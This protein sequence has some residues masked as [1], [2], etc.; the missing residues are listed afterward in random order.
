MDLGR[1]MR[2]FPSGPAN[3][4]RNDAAASVALIVAWWLDDEETFRAVRVGEMRGTETLEAYVRER[5]TEAMATTRGRRDDIIMPRLAGYG[6]EWDFTRIQSGRQAE[7]YE[8]PTRTALVR[9]RESLLA[10]VRE[11]EGLLR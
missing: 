2:F 10:R 8:R 5:A 9:E 4:T 11:I 6:L 7:H 3:R 1:A